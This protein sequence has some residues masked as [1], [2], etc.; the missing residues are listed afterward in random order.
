MEICCLFKAVSLV[1][2]PEPDGQCRRRR[3]R[4]PGYRPETSSRS[5]TS[6]ARW[7][8]GRTNGP[9]G[10]PGEQPDRGQAV[11]HSRLRTALALD[12][13]MDAAWRPGLG[14]GEPDADELVAGE[15]A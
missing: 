2:P 10:S 15:P 11:A 6:S 5:V 1:G 7:P 13:P 4:Q 9:V 14:Q 8:S 12:R 3:G